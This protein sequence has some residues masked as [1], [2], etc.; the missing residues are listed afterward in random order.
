MIRQPSSLK[1]TAP[2]F[3]TTPVVRP[4]KAGR[5]LKPPAEM[6]RLFA[7]SPEAIAETARLMEHI[8]FTLDHLRYEYPEEPVPPG[9]IPQHWLQ[10]LVWT[11]ARKH[12]G[13]VIPHKV[14]RQLAEELN[15]IKERDY[16][17]YFL[18]FFDFVRLPPEPGILNQY[19]KLV[20]SG[21]WL[22]FL[23]DLGVPFSI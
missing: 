13:G 1:P 4:A 23:L 21:T 5:Q 6:A 15:L 22:S 8:T 19:W 18:T 9:W 2:C 14:A 3:P 16:A 17:R 10:E 20:V 7:D 11:R 12:Y